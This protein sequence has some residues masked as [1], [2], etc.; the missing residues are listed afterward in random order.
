MIN[1]TICIFSL[2]IKM[3][4]VQLLSCVKRLGIHNLIKLNFTVVLILWEACFLNQSF[5]SRQQY[6]HLEF[7]HWQRT[8]YYGMPSLFVIKFSVSIW[9]M[10]IL[11]RQMICLSQHRVCELLLNYLEW[12][13]VKGENK[14]QNLNIHFTTNLF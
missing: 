14:S 13:S 4:V 3:S 1:T 12:L 5:S 8:I 9:L 11:V 6:P 10:K 2:R 7:H